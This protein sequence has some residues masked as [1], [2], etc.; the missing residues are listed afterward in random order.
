MIYDYVLACIHVLYWDLFSPEFP[1]VVM[2]VCVH[3]N[4][5]GRIRVATEMRDGHSVVITGV[6]EEL[7]VVLLTCTVLKYWFVEYE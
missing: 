1:A 7:V 3:N 6:A 5:W 4:R 2:S